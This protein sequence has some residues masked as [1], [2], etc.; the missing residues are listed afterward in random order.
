M[1][2]DNLRLLILGAHPDDAE[3]HAGGLATKYRRQGHA[4]RMVSLTDGSAGHHQMRGQDLIERR[5]REAA[6]AAALIGA[7]SEV[8]NYRDGFLQP[9][10]D[11]RL[12]VIREIRRF[13]PD[14]VLTHRPCDYHPDH[15]AVGQLV[16]DASYMVTVPSIAPEVPCLSRDPVVGYLPDR[17]T[18]PR[19][20]RADVIVEV[21]NDLETLVNMLACHE[22]QFFE[23]LPF[24]QGITH[25]VPVEVT[26]RREWLR[27]SFAHHLRS[28]TNRFRADIIAYHGPQRGEAIEFAEVFEVSEYAAPL[29]DTARA[30]LFPFVN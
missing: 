9:G 18:V 24:N 1:S 25:E 10:I 7:E 29:D 5:R 14:L 3:Y 22:S 11:V 2:D 30:R 26:A 12:D 17:F 28:L 21:G 8:W 16:Q 23:W 13:Q 15:R 20:L 19:P 27:E 6:S 4:V